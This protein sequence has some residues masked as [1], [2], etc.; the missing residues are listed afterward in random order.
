M[1]TDKEYSRDIIAADAML[2][3]TSDFCPMTFVKTKLRLEA[4]SPGEVLEVTLNEGEPLENVPRSVREMG[5][6]VV[7]IDPVPSRPGCRRLLIRKT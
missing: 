3:I 7:S 5:W 1:T 6:Q 4:M 2:D